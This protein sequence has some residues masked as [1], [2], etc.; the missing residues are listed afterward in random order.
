MHE[1]VLASVLANP[2]VEPQLAIWS[3]QIASYLFLGGLVAGLMVFSG[4]AILARREDQAPFTINRAP[5]VGLVLLALGMVMLLLDIERPFNALRIFMTVE[6]TSPMSWGA[7]FLLLATPLIGLLALAG[8]P[9]GFPVLAGWL[10]RFPVVGPRV[11]APLYGRCIAWRRPLAAL[12]VA[13]GIA[14]GVYTGVLLSAFNARPFWHSALLG[15]LFLVSGLSTGTAVVILGA[16]T[17]EERHLFSRIDLGLI[18]VELAIIALF[19]IDMLN[20]TALQRNAVA[21]LFGGD[22]TRLFW[23]GFIGLGLGI[24]FV[25]EAMSW[26]RSISI[27]VSVAAVL[28]LGGGYLLRDIVLRT[29]QETTWTQFHNQF[30][31]SLLRRLRTDGENPNGRF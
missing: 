5:L 14:V 19:V 28:V 18:V 20:G 25:I 31:S 12:N 17:T 7:W 29:G 24:P 13:F 22:V 6:I 16:R 9:A 8:L 1:E 11:I 4:W 10:S 23:I 15:P 21:H 26:R 2:R 30:D 3:W 27:V